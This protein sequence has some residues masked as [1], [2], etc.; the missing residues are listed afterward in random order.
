MSLHEIKREQLVLAAIKAWGR[1]HFKK[2]SLS[3]LAGQIGMTKA[4]LYR[5][6]R[7][8]EEL[9][10][11]AE[12]EVRDT[13]LRL[14]RA[15][16]HAA[17]RLEE[18]GRLDPPGVI[19]TYLETYFGFFSRNPEHLYFFILT[20]FKRP[21][22]QDPR[23]VT[24]HEEEEELFERALAPDGGGTQE[25]AGTPRRSSDTRRF[26]RFIFSTGVFW[27][28]TFLHG[29]RNEMVTDHHLLFEGEVSRLIDSACACA[30]HGF[31]GEAFD[32][33]IPYE[34]IEATCG[35]RHEELPE[36]DRIFGAI[37]ETVAQEGLG[38]ASLDKIAHRAG[39]SK[40]SLYFHFRNKDDMIEH[41]VSRELGALNRIFQDRA[42]AWPTTEEKLY[43]RLLVST[44]YL[45]QN[46]TV[47]RVMS[48]F[49]YQ[50]IRINMKPPSEE[51]FGPNLDFLK[52]GLAS[53]KIISRE[54]DPVR[55]L[56]LMNLLVLNEVMVHSRIHGDRP[57]DLEDMRIVYRYFTRGVA[58]RTICT[59]NS[60]TSS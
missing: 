31:A 18:A 37:S 45:S 4:G 54:L 51:S 41:L 13:Y 60:Q 21:I 5:Y 38:A 35:I 11:A 9:R 33:A 22:L 14:G 17:R 30:L 8:K 50:G 52:E 39:L 57:V 29:S 1:S 58:R 6:F 26:M 32:D 10:N 27:L 23:A 28:H 36:Q 53:G 3:S 55:I 24:L 25:A 19:R 15:F 59:E 16:V 43:T 40:S 56:G 48:W 20:T 47:M 44:S 12:E 2:T 42:A 46:R 34:R 7:N 49:H